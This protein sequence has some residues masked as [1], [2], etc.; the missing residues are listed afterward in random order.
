MIDLVAPAIPTVRW[1]ECENYRTFVRKI[2]SLVGKTSTLG[3]QLRAQVNI[4]RLT[5]N[6]NGLH[7]DDLIS[8]LPDIIEDLEKATNSCGGHINNKAA[9]LHRAVFLSKFWY[10][11]KLE[12]FYR[13]VCD[14]QLSEIC[15]VMN[16]LLVALTHYFCVI[17]SGCQWLRDEP[18][19]IKA[20]LAPP[21]AQIVLAGLGTLRICISKGL[22][23]E[24]ERADER[25]DKL[26]IN[27]IVGNFLSYVIFS[28]DKIEKENNLFKI[29]LQT[30]QVGVDRFP[31]EGLLRKLVSGLL[32][33]IETMIL[34]IHRTERGE[35][36]RKS[37]QNVEE[38]FKLVDIVAR[39]MGQNH[40]RWPEDEIP[41]R[42]LLNLFHLCV[43]WMFIHSEYYFKTMP[44]KE[45][46]PMEPFFGNSYFDYKIGRASLNIIAICFESVRHEFDPEN[47]VE[48]SSWRYLCEQMS[49]FRVHRNRVVPPGNQLLQDCRAGLGNNSAFRK[50]PPESYNPTILYNVRAREWLLRREQQALME[51]I[52][53]HQEGTVVDRWSPWNFRY[54]LTCIHFEH[55]FLLDAQEQGSMD[56][57]IN[58]WES[59]CRL[60]RPT[61]FSDSASQGEVN[62]TDVNLERPSTDNLLNFLFSI[63]VHAQPHSA[64]DNFLAARVAQAVSRFYIRDQEIHN[65]VLDR[66][67]ENMVDNFIG[68]ISEITCCI[69]P[70]AVS[71][72][73]A[74]DKVLTTLGFSW[75]TPLTGVQEEKSRAKA[76]ALVQLAQI[77]ESLIFGHGFQDQVPSSGYND[78]RWAWANLEAGLD[79]AA[80]AC[81]LVRFL[82]LPRP[83]KNSVD[84]S[85]ADKVVGRECFDL[86]LDLISSDLKNGT[87]DRGAE[88]TDCVIFSSIARVQAYQATTPGITTE[89][90]QKELTT[91]KQAN[92]EHWKGTQDSILGKY[93]DFLGFVDPRH[94]HVHIS[95]HDVLQRAV[96]ALNIVQ[97]GLK[98][99]QQSVGSSYSNHW[100][101]KDQ[102]SVLAEGSIARAI[103]DNM[104]QTIVLEAL[105]VVADFFTKVE[106]T[107]AAIGYYNQI[108]G[109]STS[110]ARRRY[111]RHAYG[112]IHLINTGDNSKIVDMTTRKKKQM[113]D[114]ASK[115]LEKVLYQDCFESFDFLINEAQFGIR[116]A[117]FKNENLLVRA[118]TEINVI[119]LSDREK[120]YTESVGV[121]QPQKYT[122]LYDLYQKLLRADFN[123]NPWIVVAIASC[124]MLKK[125]PKTYDGRAV[126]RAS[127]A[128]FFIALHL[129]DN[130]PKI[131]NKLVQIPRNVLDDLLANVVATTCCTM[132]TLVDLFRD[133]HREEKLVHPPLFHEV[134][135][136]KWLEKVPA[137]ISLSF[138]RVCPFTH[139]IIIC[140]YTADEDTPEQEG[141]LLVVNTN[142]SVRDITYKVE[143]IIAED[144]EIRDKIIAN[145]K[146]KKSGEEYDSTVSNA[147]RLVT[148]NDHMKTAC[149]DLQDVFT[150]FVFLL[151]P[152]H[153]SYK[154]NTKVLKWAKEVC[155]KDVS[156]NKVTICAKAVL[157][158]H[159]RK[160]D[161]KG[162]NATDKVLGE[163]CG[164]ASKLPSICNVSTD[165]SELRSLS[166]FI[167]PECNNVPWESLPLFRNLS[168][169]RALSA[170][171]FIRTLMRINNIES[172][173]KHGFY[174][175]NPGGD[176]NNIEK[177]L[178]H[179]FASQV[180]QNQIKWHGTVGAP[181]PGERKALRAMGEFETFLHLGH[182][183][184]QSYLAGNLIQ[185]G[186]TTKDHMGGG[187]TKPIKATTLMMGCCSAKFLLPPG[188]QDHPRHTRAEPFGAPINFLIGIFHPKHSQ[189]ITK[190]SKI[191]KKCL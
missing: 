121:F 113:Q 93:L 144:R 67:Q 153:K 63:M 1:W 84:S 71:I 101:P 179:V 143:H 6:K 166:L 72:R 2:D 89:D 9:T 75:L 58:T 97:I 112:Q 156:Y 104:K 20:K 182:G 83:S 36:W 70:K 190:Q 106:Y 76:L 149:Q 42:S 168:V 44:Q 185:Y 159:L 16:R 162:S 136:K 32:E 148:S 172:V 124:H 169:T 56:L 60:S 165:T 59:A 73:D 78:Y 88:W 19:N 186:A 111:A 180:K 109:L 130:P 69:L 103:I 167:D 62:A 49:T 118:L 150:P 141:R 22:F 160:K 50:L 177:N 29:V 40:Q 171:H 39:K 178:L 132:V 15:K 47:P 57:F 187:T 127:G 46:W 61:G 96:L 85:K 102:Y 158:G 90:L 21:R 155:G 30:L 125:A 52:Q 81:R 65:D 126:R 142:Q 74:P 137:N 23:E 181:G 92:A 175:M 176:L 98:T 152:W 147:Q 13:S 7:N 145:R 123:I 26:A 140:C 170:V 108:I 134:L 79:R 64:Q 17:T 151:L 48:L 116:P 154:V 99:V 115:L 161:W 122:R 87:K 131:G 133:L 183:H 68:Q 80:V 54:E 28:K 11:R 82:S 12:E 114:T 164:F 33:P 94:E 110:L 4:T 51:I 8:D 100:I 37:L 129:R 34:E 107:A 138:L 53:D 25:I 35:N 135:C 77:R 184:G 95:D 173:P 105:Q 5:F 38:C 146:R 43:S 45:D 41:A 157:V 24:I 27:N 191:M 139:K 14:D 188:A 55:F 66:D 31:R 117:D 189:I 174:V 18:L 10:T 91:F 3:Y 163:F 120:E 119:L 128:L 86:W